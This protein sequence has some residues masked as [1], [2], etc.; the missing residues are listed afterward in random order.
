MIFWQIKHT[1]D[2]LV[3]GWSRCQDYKHMRLAERW[4]PG[5]TK[6][7]VHVVLP[8]T[9]RYYIYY[10]PTPLE[11]S[12]ILGVVLVNPQHAVQVPPRL[13]P[14]HQNLGRQVVPVLLAPICT[15]RQTNNHDTKTR[16]K[17]NESLCHDYNNPHTYTHKHILV[18]TFNRGLF[19]PPG[20]LHPTVDI[21]FKVFT[22]DHGLFVCVW[23]LTI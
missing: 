4:V 1:N 21:H 16:T 22:D 2:K 5:K 13:D 23:V 7:F 19:F 10:L 11:E 9:W 17:K 20:I 14:H 6:H 12:L 8:G 3:I 18:Q 15:N